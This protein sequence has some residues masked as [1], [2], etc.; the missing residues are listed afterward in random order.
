MQRT[1]MKICFPFMVG[2]VCRIKQFATGSRTSLNDVQRSKLQMCKGW[3]YS[4]LAP[5]P[6]VVYCALKLQMMPDH[7]ALLRLQQKQLCS[8]WK[9]WFELTGE[10]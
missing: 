2:S 9:S 5:W 3:A 10:R 6:T 4:A 1:V 8:G 7:I